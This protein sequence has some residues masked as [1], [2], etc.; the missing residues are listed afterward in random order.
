MAVLNALPQ[1]NM[2]SYIDI[3]WA[4]IR[5]YPT[6]HTARRVRNHLPFYQRLSAAYILSEKINQFH[7]TRFIPHELYQTRL[8]KQRANL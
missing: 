3:N 5:A 1:P 7:K 2:P 4:V 6:L 8:V